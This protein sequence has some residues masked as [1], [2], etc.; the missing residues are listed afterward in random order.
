M[1]V[2]DHAFPANKLPH[3]DRSQRYVFVRKDMEVDDIGLFEKLSYLLNSVFIQFGNVKILFVIEVISGL[4][5]N[6]PAAMLTASINRIAKSDPHTGGVVFC[7]HEDIH[8]ST[9]YNKDVDMPANPSQKNLRSELR[10]FDSL[11]KMF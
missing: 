5:C 11:S 1:V 9:E 2:V 8:G 3:F 4:G 10:R 6:E 7:D